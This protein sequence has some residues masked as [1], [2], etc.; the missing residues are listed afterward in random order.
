VTEGAIFVNQMGRT[1]QIGPIASWITIGSWALAAEQRYGEAWMV[2]SDGVLH[3]DDALARAARP[4]RSADAIPSWRRRIPETAITLMKDA[5]RV[6]ENRRFRQSLSSPP[7]SGTSIRFV[8]ALHGLFFDAG[9]RWAASLGVPSVLIVDACQVEEARSWGVRR[10]G[11]SRAAEYFGER[12]QLRGADLVVCVSDEV[13]ASVTRVA[14][15]HARIAVIPNGVDTNRFSPATPD[16]GLRARLGL[17]GRFV[18]GWS[19]SFRTFHGLHTLL[20]AAAL[21]RRDIAGLTVLLVGDGLGRPAIERRAAALEVPLVL[22]GTVEYREMPDYLRLMDVAVALAPA[23]GGFHYSPVKLREYQACG[24][25][26]I[27][28]GAGEMAREFRD[29]EDVL[30]VDPGDATALAEAIGRTARDRDDARLRAT[31]ARNKV[32]ESGSWASR[33]DALEAL[34][35]ARE[36]LGA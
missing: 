18:V 4:A 7:W 2:T 31:R 20:E 16:S 23:T 11:W 22:P 6:G 30:L 36:E 27:A 8:M 5:R 10:P 19:G 28:A 12:P 29:G 9:L 34:L 14:D 13:A 3:P 33:L 32:V 26:V 24:I 15:R 17:E 21:A 35:P 1:G 25:P